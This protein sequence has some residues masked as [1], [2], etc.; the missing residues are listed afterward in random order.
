MAWNGL[1]KRL[2]NARLARG[3]RGAEVAAALDCD[4]RTLYRWERDEFEPSIASLTRLAGL[5][6]LSVDSLI[7]GDDSGTAA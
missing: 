7:Y 5:Y 1:G 4:V 6:G 2:K 3:L